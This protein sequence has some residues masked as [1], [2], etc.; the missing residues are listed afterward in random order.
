MAQELRVIDAGDGLLEVSE[1]ASRKWWTV[2]VPGADGSRLITNERGDRIS[3]EAATGKRL[4]AAVA[5][6]EA[7]RR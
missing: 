4:L 5:D 1:I 6:W 2:S 7:Q 3:S